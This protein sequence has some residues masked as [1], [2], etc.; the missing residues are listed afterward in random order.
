[1]TADQLRAVYREIMSSALELEKKSKAEL[2]PLAEMK[3]P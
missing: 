3:H 1:M 2:L